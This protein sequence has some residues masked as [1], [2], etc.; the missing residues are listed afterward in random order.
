MKV[1]KR[2]SPTRAAHSRSVARTVRRWSAA[3]SEFLQ[4]DEQVVHRLLGHLRAL[5]EDAR[6]HA[7]WRRVAQHLEMRF[8]EIAVAGIGERRE[9]SLDDDLMCE[10]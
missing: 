1:A 3:T 5:R 9:Q 6:S 8:D 7:V 4:L 2:S 10:T